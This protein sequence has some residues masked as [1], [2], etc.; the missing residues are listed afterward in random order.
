MKFQEGK[1]DGVECRNLTQYK[2][3]RG[4]LTEVFRQDELNGYDPALCYISLTLPGVTRGPHEH[5]EQTDWFVF[6][7]PG[8]FEIHLWDNR[9]NS[10]TYGHCQTLVAGDDCPTRVIVPPGVVHGYKNVSDVPGLVV[11]CPDRLFAGWNRS[12]PVD[13]IRHEDDENTSFLIASPKMR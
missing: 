8:E 7:G 5:K 3:H 10:A 1:I 11:N 9:E 6:T 2:D 13:E 12:E 4:W